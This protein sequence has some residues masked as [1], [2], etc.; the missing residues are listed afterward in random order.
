[1]AYALII[2]RRLPKEEKMLIDYFGDDYLEYI[3][4]TGKLFPRLSSFIQQKK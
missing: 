1:M 3:K 2:F 4:H